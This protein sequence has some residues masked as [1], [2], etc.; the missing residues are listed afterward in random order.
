[1]P[2]LSP[3]RIPH[4]GI[5]RPLPKRKVGGDRDDE[6]RQQRLEERGE[7]AVLLGVLERCRR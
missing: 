3:R 2:G 4:A 1:M 6:Q 5:V 7:G